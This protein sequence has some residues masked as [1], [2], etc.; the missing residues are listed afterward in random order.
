MVR[1]QA[2]AGRV[3]IRGMVSLEPW[4]VPGCG[5]LNLLA[6][7]EVCEGDTSHDRQ[8]A[9]DLFMELAAEY[10]RPL[11]GTL[12]W[13]VYGGLAGEPA[14]GPAGFPHRLSAMPTPLAPIA[15]HWL[16]STHITHGLVTTGIFTRRWKLEGSVFNGREPDEHRADL[17]LAALDSYSARLSVAPT[18][19]LALQ[20]SAAMLR[21]AEQ[22]VGRQGRADVKRATASA[23]YHR[24][25]RGG[26]LATTV[27]WGVNNEDEQLPTGIYNLTTNALL[28]ESALVGERHT[29]FG[30]AELA[31]KPAHDLHA[32]E[33]EEAVFTV[34]KLSVGY[35]RSLRAWSGFVPG[36]GGSVTLNAVPPALSVKYDG[37]VRPGFAVFFNLRPAG[38]S[39]GTR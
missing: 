36:I 14:L 31:A 39:M 27:A 18:S 7:G 23:T 4:T 10:E 29:W 35:T 38:H 26:T 15:H 6:S 20:M 22:G 5:Y 33:Y 8:H 1:R 2:G 32:H 11:G 37:R 21:E 24:P 30:R 34:G 3:G 16:D 25:L 28:A 12:N 19:R 9:H 13:Q 17:D